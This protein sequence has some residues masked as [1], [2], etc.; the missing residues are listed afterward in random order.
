DMARRYWDFARLRHGR[1]LQQLAREEIGGTPLT[2]PL[3]Y[4]RRSPDSFVRQLALSRVPL[5][6]YWST[7]DRVIRDQRDE[8]GALVAEIRGWNPF[9]PVLSVRGVWG[10]T[11]EMWPRGR[12]P[13]ALAW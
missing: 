8:A 1:R 2:A 3:A 7:R 11:H 9:A 13:E 12:L 10:H 5:A 6:F 4:A